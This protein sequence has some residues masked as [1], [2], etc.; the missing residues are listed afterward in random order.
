MKDI[1]ITYHL[2]GQ[3]YCLQ[4]I[5]FC[6]K[7]ARTYDLESKET[8]PEKKF[9]EVVWNIVPYNITANE[10]KQGKFYGEKHDDFEIEYYTLYNLLKTRYV[11]K[12][13]NGNY[14]SQSYYNVYYNYFC[15]NALRP[16]SQEGIPLSI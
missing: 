1:P 3:E 12:S 7:N 6:S 16:F 9:G 5:I 4:G 2:S 15:V 11:L 13:K 8:L 14:V 10:L